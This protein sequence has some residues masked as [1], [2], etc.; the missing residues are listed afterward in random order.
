MKQSYLILCFTTL[1]LLTIIQCQ[2]I[3]GKV[4][5]M[6]DGLDVAIKKMLPHLLRRIQDMDL[7]PYSGV[8]ENFLLG[9]IDYE[10]TN[11]KLG[12]FSVDNIVLKNTAPNRMDISR[13]VQSIMN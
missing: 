9:K 8:Y 6:K 11:L 12:T 5:V 10:L 3:A 2:P 4:V 13:F 7:P 1:L